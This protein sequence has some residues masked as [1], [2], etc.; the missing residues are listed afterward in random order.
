M[1]SPCSVCNYHMEKRP[2]GCPLRKGIEGGTDCP[3]YIEQ[4]LAV[5]KINLRYLSEYYGVKNG[6]GSLYRSLH[7]IL[8]EI[9]PGDSRKLHDFLADLPHLMLI[10]HYTPLPYQ[11]IV[12]TNY[13]DMLEQSFLDAKQPFDLVFYDANVNGGGEFRYRSHEGD[14]QTID[15]KNLP[16]LLKFTPLD[17]AS[18]LR[19]IILKLFGSQKIPGTYQDC[20]VASEKQ[21]T[22]LIDSLSKQLPESLIN[23]IK[24]NSILFMGYSP[25]DTDVNRIVHSLLQGDS[26]ECKSWLLHQSQVGDLDKRI[27]DK[28]NVKLLKMPSLLEDFV[29][30]LKGEVE[31]IPVSEKK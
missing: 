1:G 12:T 14:V 28:R 27:W 29:A 24:Y 22:L 26:F 10:K 31:K 2:D 9:D 4:E 25:N 19:P 7:K 15:N 17:H 3:L 18:Q 21:L 6:V 11:L 23:T 16:S 13:D 5:S 30:Q 8:E 20:F